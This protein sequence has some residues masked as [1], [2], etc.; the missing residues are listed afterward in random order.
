MNTGKAKFAFI[1]CSPGCPACHV[2]IAYGTNLFANSAANTFLGNSERASVVERR[3]KSVH[4]GNLL[5]KF[6]SGIRC[7]RDTSFPAFKVKEYCGKLIFDLFVDFLLLVHI[8]VGEIVINHFYRCDE[9]KGETEFIALTVSVFGA[10][11]IIFAVGQ[12]H[13]KIICFEF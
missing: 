13:I 6:S 7:G 1:V 4:L 11:A 12:D 5:V 9:V 10:V 3:E 8:K 2:E